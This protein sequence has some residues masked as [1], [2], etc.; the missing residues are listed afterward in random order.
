[1]WSSSLIPLCVEQI[2]STIVCDTHFGHGHFEIHLKY[3][4]WY[5][6]R[7]QLISLNGTLAFLPI[8]VSSRLLLFLRHC[9]KSFEHF[10]NISLCLLNAKLRPSMCMDMDKLNGQRTDHLKLSQFRCMHFASTQTQT[11][12]HASECVR[13]HNFVCT[14]QTVSHQSIVCKVE[15]VVRWWWSMLVLLRTVFKIMVPPHKPRIG[16]QPP[17]NFSR[18]F[19]TLVYL[20]N[21]LFCSKHPD[22]QTHI[23]CTVS[24]VNMNSEHATHAD[25]FRK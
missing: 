7:S 13:E 15:T 1:M 5:Q 12:M 3:L 22:T 25:L 18:S 2:F 9:L 11:H 10:H 16:L 8:P 6:T 24:P 17:F 4:D 14:S 23:D 20:F 21:A 19:H